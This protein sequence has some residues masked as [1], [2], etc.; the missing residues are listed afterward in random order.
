M[1]TLSRK[2]RDAQQQ[3]S[4]ITLLAESRQGIPEHG[5]GLP[6][7]PVGE[8][9]AGRAIHQ[10]GVSA[11]FSSRELLAQYGSICEQI[12]L[13]VGAT[14]KGAGWDDEREALQSLLQRQGEKAKRELY[15]L[16]H[17]ES[18]ESEELPIDGASAAD[19]DLWNRYAMQT[20]ME[21][22]RAGG[23]IGHGW[24]MVMKRA[25]RAVHRMVQDLPKESE[26]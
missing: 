7:E 20:K 10:S 19:D 8:K 25:Q 2:T 13:G 14:K 3:A 15:Y 1:L 21:E 26:R 12:T 11:I 5:A 18:K 22:E 16:L 4:F 9:S 17:I 23:N 24:G 6:K